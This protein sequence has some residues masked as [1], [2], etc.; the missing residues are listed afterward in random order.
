MSK[1]LLGAALAAFALSGCPSTSGNGTDAAPDVAT[2]GDA[3]TPPA[4]F[5]TCTTDLYYHAVCGSDGKTYPNE[6]VALYC[7]K[8][9]IAHEG[10]CTDG[11]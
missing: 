7:A 5:S 3:A 6:E 8:V 2:A 10:P 11:G 1:R 9:Q 4:D